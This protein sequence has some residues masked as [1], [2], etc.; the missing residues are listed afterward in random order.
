MEYFDVLDHYG[1]KTGKIAAKGA[2][3]QDGEFY[4]GVHV[5]IHTPQNEFLLQRRAPDKEFLP[6]E[7]DVHMGHVIAGETPQETAVREVMEE[8]GLLLSPDGLRHI[9]RAE[10]EG[11]HHFAD[12][13]FAQRE[14][15]LDQLILQ[16]EEVTDAKLIPLEEMVAMTHGMHYRPAAYRRLVLD[17]LTT[18]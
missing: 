3:L 17:C 12:I 4:L 2:A 15:V 13:F 10:W 7:W 5:Y 11:K 1:N 16:P 6:D 14:V 9:G 18:L 8:V